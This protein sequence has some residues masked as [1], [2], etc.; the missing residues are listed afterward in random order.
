MQL[1]KN[2]EKYNLNGLAGTADEPHGKKPHSFAFVVIPSLFF[3]YIFNHLPTSAMNNIVKKKSVQ[4]GWPA[5]VHNLDLVP[6][7]IDVNRVRQGPY[8]KPYVSMYFKTLT[9]CTQIILYTASC[10][11]LRW[12]WRLAKI[13]EPLEKLI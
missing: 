2:N 5:S 8:Q 4:K 13:A 3:K 9:E 1:L 12:F 7:K 6:E 10:H 11:K